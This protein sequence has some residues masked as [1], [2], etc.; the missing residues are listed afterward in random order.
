MNDV[1]NKRNQHH[2]TDPAK[3]LARKKLEIEYWPS[4]SSFFSI[5]FLLFKLDA[6][7]CKLAIEL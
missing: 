4:I 3:V 7:A 6:A 5:S 1:A 2:I